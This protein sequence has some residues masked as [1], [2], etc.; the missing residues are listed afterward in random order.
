LLAHERSVIASI[1]DGERAC[2]GLR[3]G[4]WVMDTT[5]TT[6]NI[7]PVRWEDYLR[8]VDPIYDT[9][10]RWNDILR[11]T[12]LQ[13]SQVKLKI[14]SG[15]F[16]APFLISDSGRSLGWH[17]SE[18]SAW[19]ASRDALREAMRGQPRGMAIHRKDAQN[20]NKNTRPKRVAKKKARAKR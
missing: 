17:A 2:F 4:V 9:T 20:H 12:G 1:G 18:V 11:I 7:Q 5:T 10:L 14:T 16:P 3:D 19:C 15:Q 6:T 8:K 13:K